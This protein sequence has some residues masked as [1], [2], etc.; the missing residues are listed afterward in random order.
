MNKK[1]LSLILLLL[2]VVLAIVG[3]SSSVLENIA[4]SGGDY[5]F[6]YAPASSTAA[7]APQAYNEKSSMMMA[8][9]GSYDEAAESD[10]AGMAMESNA[11][12]GLLS[13][14]MPGAQKPTNRKII[15]T[16][17]INA[18]TTDF[19]NSILSIPAAVEQYGGYIESSSVSGR[20]I[21]DRKGYNTRDAYFTLRI[22]SGSIHK[23]VA[24]LGEKYNIVNT[25]EFSEDITDSYFDS[26][27]RLKSLEE[28]EK[29]LTALLEKGEELQ[30]LLEVQREISHVRYQIESVYSQLQRMDQSVDFST[31]RIYLQ[32]VMIYQQ[33]DPVPISF[34]ERIRLALNDSVR[35]FGISLQ[36]DIVDFAYGFMFIISDT[37]RLII[38]V[39]IVV[40]VRR[41]VRKRKK[42]VK[43]QPTFNWPWIK[44]HAPAAV[45]VEPAAPEAIEK[46]DTENAE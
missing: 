41:F 9:Y 27:A 21:N 19:D 39:L 4:Y 28:Q 2:C 22:P 26:K 1:L 25:Q 44:K 13:S 38:F 6:S 8:D 15:T 45:V 37:I 34:G 7:A 33:V 36:N 32:E 12:A 20:S 10:V 31:V 29:Q 11:E 14:A 23:F 5:A 43:G 42:L 16:F 35:S 18:E 40:I 30:Y 17:D 46:P 24:E 3:C